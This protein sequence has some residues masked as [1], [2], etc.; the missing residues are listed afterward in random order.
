MKPQDVGRAVS[1]HPR[2]VAF[3]GGVLSVAAFAPFD[4]FFIPLIS[5][6]LL[7]HIWLGQTR[8][9]AAR[10]AWLFGVGFLGFGVSWLYISI[11]QFGNVGTPLAI[12]ATV[13]F[14]LFVALFYAL[15]GALAGVVGKG[16]EIKLLLVFPA[17]W[18][19]AEWLR[20]WVLT[21]FPWLVLGYSQI[22]SPLGGYAPLIGVYGVSWLLAL[23]AALLVSAAGGR[24]VVSIVGIALI[25]LGGWLLSSQSWTT[26][27]GER[28]K[29]ALV[30]ANIP[31]Y[32][33]WDPAMRLPTIQLYSRL[34]RENLDVDLVI[35]PETAV[36]DFLH[37]L[38]DSFV[39]PFA[40]EL[41][42]ADIGL[43]TGVPVLDSKTGQ[44]YNAAVVAGEPDQ[45]YFKRH[46]VPFGEFLP[47]KP[48]LGP[49][50]D[51]MEIPMSDFSVG[52]TGR[53]LVRL[54]GQPVGVSICYEDA[55]GEEVREALPEA[56]YLVNLSN[57]A[58]FGDS[59]AP[60]QHLQIARMR[61]LE[62]GRPMLR[63]TNTGISAVIDA[64]GQL[65]AVSDAFEEIV[66]RG[67]IQPMSGSTPFVRFGNLPVLLLVLVA[68]LAG[69]VLQRRGS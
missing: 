5:L 25:W 39:T 26:P 65:S 14:V 68:L 3:F 35:W 58:W 9:M 53:P 61:S 51:F 29:V 7:F 21:G 54:R 49:L 22:D 24:R 64:K 56:A 20:G 28:L 12:A 48:W 11:D 66:L 44:Y 4:L 41:S 47:F 45:Q 59:L 69:F 15:A 2:S 16:R 32:M 38:D 13:L 30:Q 8:C 46:L 50:L 17:A 31:Q 36:P 34:T 42:V 1:G 40:E 52:Q 18:V 19:L 10:G 43:L 55:F 62:T 37:R 27:T 67:E 60:H 33:K 23:S 6:S 63:A 57:D